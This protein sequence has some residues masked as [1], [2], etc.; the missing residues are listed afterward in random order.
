MAQEEKGGFFENVPALTKN[1]L[2]IIGLFISLIYGFGSIVITFSKDLSANEKAPLIWFLVL[3]PVLVLIAFVYLVVFHHKKLY[4]PGDYKDEQ[5][6]VVT[7]LP[8]AYQRI[9]MAEEL[10]LSENLEEEEEEEE[11]E[12]P[13]QERS[14]GSEQRPRSFDTTN[15]HH[16]E[17]KQSLLKGVQTTVQEFQKEYRD[18]ENSLF[19]QLEMEL[20]LRLQKRVMLSFGHNGPIVSDAFLETDNQVQF[21]MVKYPQFGLIGNNFKRQAE[22]FIH[23]IETVKESLT[24]KKK[25]KIV[26]AIGVQPAYRT[27][28]ENRLER[29]KAYGMASTVQ[30]EFRIFEV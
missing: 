22:R 7:H 8:E 19:E 4:G 25:V 26:F 15:E 13:L 9:K 14:Y 30:V 27:V 6:F 12:E 1:P 17:T 11:E 18:A 21:I 5:N 3:F 16:P 20:G 24:P 29:I 10:E 23:S 2:G 28:L